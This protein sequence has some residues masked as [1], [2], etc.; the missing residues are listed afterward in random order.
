MSLDPLLQP[1]QLKHLTLKNRLMTTAH[2]PNFGEDGLPKDRYRKYH[3]ERAKGGLALT[4]FGGNPA[5]WTTQIGRPRSNRGRS[6]LSPRASA[7][8]RS[9]KGPIRWT[10]PMQKQRTAEAVRPGIP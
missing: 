9:F 3:V 7:M 2:E 10:T 1:Y 6:P 5:G 4:M 8:K